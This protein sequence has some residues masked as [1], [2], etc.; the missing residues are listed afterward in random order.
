M[1]ENRIKKWKEF[2]EDDKYS[3]Y[4]MTTEEQWFIRSNNKRPPR[5][6]LIDG[7]VDEEIKILC[8]WLHMQLSNYKAKK[9]TIHKN[10]EIRKI[11]ENTMNDDFFG[12][13]LKSE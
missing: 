8:G 12:K 7:Y 1:E 9:S 2:I 3:E 5:S 11:W 4:F 10:E 13:C 6:G